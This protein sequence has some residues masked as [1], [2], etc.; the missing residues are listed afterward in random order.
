LT[1]LEVIKRRH[2]RKPGRTRRQSL[3]LLGGKPGK[4][5]LEERKYWGRAKKRTDGVLATDGKRRGGGS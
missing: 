5:H 3:E 2:S 4:N 1:K